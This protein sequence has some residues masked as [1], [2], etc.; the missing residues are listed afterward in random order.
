MI[1]VLNMISGCIN[2]NLR[3]VDSSILLDSSPTPKYTAAASKLIDIW[4][5]Q[6]GIKIHFTCAHTDFYEWLLIISIYIATSMGYSHCKL[7]FE[8]KL[9][10]SWASGLS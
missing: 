3:H 1:D 6:N 7:D 5:E 4:S 9:E 8:N 2:C 10:N